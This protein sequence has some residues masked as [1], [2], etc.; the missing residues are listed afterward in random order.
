MK[1]LTIIAKERI[2]K[3]NNEKHLF[4]RLSELASNGVSCI[5][6]ILPRKEV[7]NANLPN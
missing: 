5:L 6:T 1:D 3:F 2:Y 7:K 4:S